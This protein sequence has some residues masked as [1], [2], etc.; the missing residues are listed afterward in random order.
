MPWALK[1]LEEDKVETDT[2]SEDFNQ[3][4]SNLFEQLTE[5]RK[6]LAEDFLSYLSDT[7]TLEN[8]QE[9]QSL[10]MRK[11][12][13][14]TSPETDI[15]I[16]TEE[17]FKKNNPSDPDESNADILNSFYIDDLERI[18]ASHEKRRL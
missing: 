18:I 14:S 8:L 13:W 4:K 16:R 12:K 7:Q 15:Y 6:E 2:W 1:Q 11:L 17:V 3:L 9:I 10:I 5:N